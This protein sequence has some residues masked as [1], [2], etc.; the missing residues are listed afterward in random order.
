MT[1]R[2]DIRLLRTQCSVSPL[3]PFAFRSRQ[4]YVNLNFMIESGT[5]GFAATL[6]FEAKAFW[7]PSE[8]FEQLETR[9]W[10]PC[11]L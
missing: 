8:F 5:V 1:V 10:D 6:M 2:N 9:G 3:P 7:T 4:I 11:V